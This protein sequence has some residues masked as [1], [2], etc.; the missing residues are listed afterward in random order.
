MSKRPSLIQEVLQRFDTLKAFGESRHALKSAQRD[1]L[2]AE[3]LP[4][5]WSH[6]TGKIHSL[7]TADTYKR[8]VLDYAAWARE[9]FGVH[10]LAVLDQRAHEL[11]AVWLRLQL[12]QHKSPSTVQ[13][14][15]SALRMFHHDRHLG[16]AVTI[17]KRH[18]EE[19]R[20]SRGETP[21][22]RR[23]NPE[24]WH[25][26]IAFLH[27]TG[28]RRREVTS[29]RVRHI[30]GDEWD[31]MSVQ[32]T[33]G[34][35][36]RARTVVVLHGAEPVVQRLIAEK[37]P[38]D[39]VFERIPS[40]LDVHACRRSYAQALY[41]SM[42]SKPLPP[43]TGRLPV[44]SYDREAVENVSWCLGHRRTDVVLRHYLR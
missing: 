28:L 22:D 34:K 7:G 17:P 15:R 37:R 39:K 43:A 14:Q 25:D 29:L 8:Q 2:R 35:G 19:I 13:M 9:T 1:K 6:S 5:R 10:R 16:D 20:R 12:D 27:A 36:G 31:G 33:N 4:I 30:E 42:T 44:G 21:T 41:A 32:V 26:L 40:A 23:I 38:E 11:A 24:R 3:G 18:R